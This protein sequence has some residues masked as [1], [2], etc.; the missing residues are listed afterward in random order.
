M[1]GRRR[2][3]TVGS[4]H[5]VGEAADL[6]EEALVEQVVH[7]RHA[8]LISGAEADTRDT[9][10]CGGCFRDRLP[11]GVARRQRFLDENMD[12]VPQRCDREVGVGVVG[13]RDQHGVDFVQHRVEVFGDDEIVWCPRVRRRFLGALDRRVD[14]RADA[15]L[16]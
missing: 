5:L 12:T 3:P 4:A 7:E 8:R 16:R 6:S 9:P 15:N 14:Q 13:R 1:E 11:V 2:I 10:A